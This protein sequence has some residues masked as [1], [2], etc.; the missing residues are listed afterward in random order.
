MDRTESSADHAFDYD[1]FMSHA[2][3]NKPVVHE[4][5]ARLRADGV[6]VWLDE[7][8]IKPGDSI[9]FEIERGFK[10][11]HHVILAISRK[12]IESPWVALERHAALYRDPSNRVRK[13]I[14]LLLDNTDVPDVLRHL[15][16]IDWRNRSDVEYEKL[17]KAC[18]RPRSYWINKSYGTVIRRSG[19]HLWEEIAID[20]DKPKWQLHELE[21]TSEFIVLRNEDRGEE[22]RVFRDR[23]EMN[24]DGKR[25]VIAHGQWREPNAPF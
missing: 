4:L 13:L 19:N 25:I 23:V 15:S 17:L 6:V 5:A 8:A 24:R 14:P 11:S 20:S 18:A 1:L 16:H 2:S 10:L 22:W 21:E 3:D 12:A 7:W 9:P